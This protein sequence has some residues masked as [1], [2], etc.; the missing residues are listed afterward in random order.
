M[1]K[2]IFRRILAKFKK[3]VLQ[4]RGGVAC[5]YRVSTEAQATTEKT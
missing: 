5:Y 4:K 1:I 3:P 2:K